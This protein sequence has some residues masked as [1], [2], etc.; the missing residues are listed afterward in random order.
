MTDKSERRRREV[1]ETM[2]DMAASHGPDRVTTRLIAQRLG[3]SEPALYRHFPDGK[4]GMWQA[5]AGVVSERMKAAWRSALATAPVSAPE[6]LRALVTC[7]L[8]LIAATPALPAIL[9]SRTLHR[10][11]AALRTGIAAVA[12]RFHARLEQIVEDG[13][14]K[15][16]LRED[17]DADAVAWLLIS[18]VQGTAIR[19]SL[20]DRGFDLEREGARVLDTALNGIE[21]VERGS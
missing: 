1:V 4:P 20:S 10:D 16:E 6:R 7:Q 5:L 15:G 8:D 3:V 2:L 19:W 13:R 14:R 9:F 12:A 21:P 18:V 11:N 17:L